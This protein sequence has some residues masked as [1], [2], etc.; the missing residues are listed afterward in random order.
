MARQ[1]AGR[2]QVVGTVEHDERLLGNHL[3]PARP[4]IRQEPFADALGE[5]SGALVSRSSQ[6]ASTNAAFCVW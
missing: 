1:L 3:Q 5:I 6:A 4:A 2:L